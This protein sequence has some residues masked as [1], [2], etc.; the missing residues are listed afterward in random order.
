[1]LRWLKHGDLRAIVR[2][3][4][5]EL[6]PL[7]PHPHPEGRKL[8]KEMESRLAQ[9]ETLV[10]AEG[11][12]PCAFLH[13]IIQQQ[14]LFVDLLAVDGSRQSKGY[15]T[16]LM[17]RA[18]QHAAARGC[19]RAMLYVD[20]GNEAGVRFYRRLGY[21]VVAYHETLKCY[22]MFKRLQP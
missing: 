4:R 17:K 5:R 8:R 2:I 21:N 11:G 13:L 12:K 7:S 3:V 1:M 22:E 14:T 18:E 15:G 20:E 16:R 6:I 19:L 9:G 10:A